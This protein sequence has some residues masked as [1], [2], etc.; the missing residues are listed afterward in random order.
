M[1]EVSK[2]YG[3]RGWYY[4]D[5][6]Y[7]EPDEF[8]GMPVIGTWHRDTFQVPMLFGKQVYF[9]Q[10]EAHFAEL[11]DGRYLIRKS[12]QNEAMT[13]DDI[14]TAIAILTDQVKNSNYEYYRRKIREIFIT[15]LVIFVLVGGFIWFWLAS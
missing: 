1:A 8:E 12:G 13:D 2:K 6:P 14:D 11:K 9:T 7:Y 3:Y 15:Y 5:G 10:S 4:L